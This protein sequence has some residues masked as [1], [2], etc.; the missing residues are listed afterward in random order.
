MTTIGERLRIA[1]E[2]RGLKQT[3]VKER[4]NINNKTLSGYENNVSQPDTETLVVLADLY[5]VSYEWLFA[6]KGE[7]LERQSGKKKSDWNSKLPELT[8]KDEKDIAADLEK[9]INDLDSASGYA[10]FDG[11]SI[12]ELSEDEIE[13][14]ELLLSSLENSLRLAKR[15]AKQK[16]TPKKYRD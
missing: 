14:R 15:I 1:R 4:T 5:E 13:D 9:M 10:A 16:F 2:K 11:R 8:A 12:D 6:G 3:Q 7:M